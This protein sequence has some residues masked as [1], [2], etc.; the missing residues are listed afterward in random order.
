M[1]PIA[2]FVVVVIL[3]LAAIV[4]VGGLWVS[5]WIGDIPLLIVLLTLGAAAVG[6]LGGLW[7]GR[8]WVRPVDR[9]DG[10]RRQAAVPAPWRS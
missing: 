9:P 4:S 2:L 8:R 6:G 7:V 3:P 1:G 5:T 10:G